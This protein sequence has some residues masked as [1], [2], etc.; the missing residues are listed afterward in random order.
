MSLT[1]EKIPISEIIQMVADHYD[2]DPRTMSM[3]WVHDG[4]IQFL[5][6]TEDPHNNIEDHMGPE[7]TTEVMDYLNNNV[8][9]GLM[10]HRVSPDRAFYYTD[11]EG[12][13]TVWFEHRDKTLFYREEELGFY[14]TYDL[15]IPW[16]ACHSVIKTT[17]EKHVEQGVN[18]VC[19]TT[20]GMIEKE[21]E[22]IRI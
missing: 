3:G 7:K 21:Y 20:V 4:H 22:L 5:I 14:L 13:L 9:T 15:E 2:L 1:I 6:S 19:V 12:K 16:D 8:F 10:E 11:R 17:F 18:V